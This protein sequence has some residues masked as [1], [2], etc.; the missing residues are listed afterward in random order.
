MS[1]PPRAV[2]STCMW[3]SSRLYSREDDSLSGL[4]HEQERDGRVGQKETS[5][6]N[7]ID[8]T[9]Q[10]G[11]D[12]LLLSSQQKLERMGEIPVEILGSSDEEVADSSR[13]RTTKTKTKTPTLVRPTPIASTSRSSQRFQTAHSGTNGDSF[14]SP[15]SENTIFGAAGETSSS[16]E[17]PSF[18]AFAGPASPSKSRTVPTP[19]NSPAKPVTPAA[20]A[21]PVARRKIVLTVEEQQKLQKQREQE[22]EQ[23]DFFTT[24]ASITFKSKAGVSKKGR[25]KGLESKSDKSILT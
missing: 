25:V 13:K 16:Q 21:R 6:I 23:D 9:I 15:T 14:R 2:S 18:A 4:L 12:R 7:V 11:S 17:A 20:R 19:P 10:P 5:M 8:K 24:R 1:T 3:N 22:Q